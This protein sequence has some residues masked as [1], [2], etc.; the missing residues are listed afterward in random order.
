MPS[1]NVDLPDDLAEQVRARELSVS[2]I[3]ARALR[4]EISHLQTIEQAV[5]IIVQVG[6]PALDIGFSGRWLVEPDRDKTRAGPDE[7]AYWG[8]ALTKRARI[9]VYRAHVNKP[10]SLSDYD[11]LDNATADEV[12]E[13]IIA[14]AKAAL[15]E[16]HVIWRDI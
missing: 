13:E 11:T 14:F 2:A 16:A 5:G 15:G 10:A 9:A 7:G 4:D 3:C 12:P 1:F 8:V 6:E